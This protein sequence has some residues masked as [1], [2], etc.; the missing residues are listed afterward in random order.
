MVSLGIIVALGAIFAF[1]AVGYM[2]QRAQIIRE[3]DTATLVSASANQRMLSQ[4][5]ALL[6]LAL[7]NVQ[8]DTIRERAKKALLSEIGVMESTHQ[9]L[10]AGNPE[11]GIRADKSYRIREIFFG[12]QI[13]LDNRVR[14]FIST[15]RALAE[16]DDKGLSSLNPKLYQLTES[17]TEL[18]RL[19]EDLTGQYRQEGIEGMLELEQMAT[20]L[21]LAQLGLILCTALF[22][23]YPLIRRL[24][25]EFHERTAAQAELV[26]QNQELEQFA[27]TVAHDLKAPLNNIGGFSQF[28]RSKLANQEDK[29]TNEILEFIESGVRRMTKMIDELLQYARLTRK[30]RRVERVDLSEVVHKV[31]KDYAKNI[32]DL[33]AK[34]EVGALPVIIGDRLQLEHLFLNLIG[35][36]LKYR[37]PDRVPHISVNRL[38]EVQFHEMVTIVVEDNGRGF[39]AGSEERMFEPF[40]RLHPNEAVEGSGFGLAL[41]RKIARRHNGT[42][43]AELGAT[44]GARFI[45]SLSEK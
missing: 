2:L 31:C 42:I 27:A 45:V 5:L 7:I 10:I 3:R 26:E 1:Q 18:S 22:I 17:S 20:Q 19:F 28:L 8:S 39:P 9:A 12:D 30:Q 25:K 4:R 38:Q 37:H 21:L 41:C 44:G 33:N 29:E 43:S 24:K 35:N 13:A 40:R 11:L 34:I 14:E 23:F 6:S 36:A 32:S 15:A 16:S